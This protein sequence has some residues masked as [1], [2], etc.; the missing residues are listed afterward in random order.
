MGGK[1]PH[2]FGVTANESERHRGKAP[3]ESKL[4]IRIMR[5]RVGGSIPLAGLNE[6]ATYGCAEGEEHKLLCEFIPADTRKFGTNFRSVYLQ[7][8]EGFI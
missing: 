1:F 5:A 7:V 3:L 2:D 8:V 4:A 6:H